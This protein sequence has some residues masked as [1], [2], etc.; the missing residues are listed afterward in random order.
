MPGYWHAP[1]PDSTEIEVTALVA[2]F[3]TALQ[4]EYV[5]ETGTAFGQTALAIGHALQANGHG[6]LDTIEP[7]P[8]RAAHCRDLLS[9][10][11]VTLHEQTSLTFTPA[12]RIDFAWFD[13]LIDLR[14][15]EFHTY[16]QHMTAETII[17]FHD[18]G[19]QHNLR[20]DVE[21]LGTAGLIRPIYLPT[22]RGVVFAQVTPL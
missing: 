9:A 6:R 18:C 1:D 10:L 12:R 21:R 3:V 8:V 14:V 19:P 11:P 13:S 2:A 4:P 15:P 5:V 16:R 22:P 20:P 7:D 17:G